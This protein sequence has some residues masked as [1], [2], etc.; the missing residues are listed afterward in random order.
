MF[1]ENLKNL[2]KSKGLSQEE[3][4]IRLSVV[5]QTV[6]KWENGLSVPD[7]DLIIKIAEALDTSVSVLLGEEVIADEQ[8]ELKAIAQKLEIINSQLAQRNEKSR[9]MKSGFFIALGIIAVA[10]ILFLLGDYF[11]DIQM[12]KEMDSSLAIIGGAD[13]PTSIFVTTTDTRPIKL[14]AALLALIISAAGIY[15][16]KKHRN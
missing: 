13:G 12:M 5:R 15:K 10:I 11:F 2:R 14:A 6:S 3:L 1:S 16:T 7:S 8:S 9:K 4:A